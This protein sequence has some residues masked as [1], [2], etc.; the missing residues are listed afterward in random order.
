MRALRLLGRFLDMG[1]W[2]VDL[3]LSVGIFPYVLK[4]LQTTL[5]EL[6]C[7]LVFI[8]CKILALDKSCQQDL[9]KDQSHTYF[10]KILQQPPEGDVTIATHAQVR[11]HCFKVPAWKILGFLSDL[12]KSM[13]NFASYRLC[14]RYMCGRNIA[15]VTRKITHVYRIKV[16]KNTFIYF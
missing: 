10:L 16:S 2:T 5:A 11:K 6:R 8:W 15:Y 4:L 14:G 12:E 3:A 7:S 1:A 13:P 9:I